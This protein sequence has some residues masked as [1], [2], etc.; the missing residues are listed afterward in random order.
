[1][2]CYNTLMK[3]IL[4][5]FYAQQTLIFCWCLVTEKVNGTLYV[6]NLS[7][8]IFCCAIIGNICMGPLKGF[9]DR[10]INNSRKGRII[11]GIIPQVI[12]GGLVISIYYNHSIATILSLI[13]WH[14]IG[15]PFISASDCL[16][17]ESSSIILKSSSSFAFAQY[18]GTKIIARIGFS[19]ISDNYQILKEMI[20]IFS[21]ASIAFGI[22]VHLIALNYYP[23]HQKIYSNTKEI[24]SYQK[25]IGY[26][27]VI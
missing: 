3:V 15:M 25:I 1:M 10:K 26:K 4:T 11:A 27:F 18:I 12:F 22:I 14:L 16:M 7:T 17:D 5:L 2:N 24:N 9:L 21:L 20:T 19:Y 13:M 6:G 8:V 23:E